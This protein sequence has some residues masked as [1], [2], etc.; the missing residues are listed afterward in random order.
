[1]KKMT[2]LCVAIS[3]VMIASA[4]VANETTLCTYGGKER[5]ISVVYQDQNKKTPCEVQ[6]QKDGTMQTLW[7]AEGEVGYCEEQAKA[8][9]EKQR[10]WGWQCEEVKAGE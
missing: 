3:L 9:I 6:Y 8:F 10:G 5:V 2:I 7:S 4:A 1:M